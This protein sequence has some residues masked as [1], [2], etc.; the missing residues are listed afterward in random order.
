D[1]PSVQKIATYLRE[2]SGKIGQTYCLTT[3]IFFLDRLGN[4]R[5]KDL[6]ES[7]ALRI[8]AGQNSW[9]SWT[10][11]CPILTKDEEQKLLGFLK[12]RNYADP[13]NPSIKDS[14]FDAAVKELPSKLRELPVAQKKYTPRFG[15]SPG[16]NSNTQFGLLALW[17]AKRH[18]VPV[19]PALGLVDK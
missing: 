10:Y 14:D 11:A 19:Q 2:R 9:G 17:I 13:E 1:D 3:A 7:F 8:I 6:I 16:D 12:T 4:P 18:G 5:D 15:D